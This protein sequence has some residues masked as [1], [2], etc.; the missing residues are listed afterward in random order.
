MKSFAAIF[1]FLFSAGLLFA[2]PEKNASVQLDFS[3]A[4]EPGKTYF[5]NV[6]NIRTQNC[7]LKY[8]G[9]RRIP[10]RRDSSET[11]LAGMLSYVSKSDDGH[12]IR[13]EFICRID[14]LS[15]AVNGRRLEFP[16]LTGCSLH[17]TAGPGARCSMK[18]T[19]DKAAEEEQAARELLEGG[20]SAGTP[21]LSP[22]AEM[23]LR[24]VFTSVPES[25][26]AYLGT[27]RTFERGEKYPVAM[28]MLV[29]ALRQRKIPA[30]A[31]KIDAFAEYAGT[32][33]FYGFPVCRVDLLA[34]GNGIPGYDFKLEVS[35]FMPAEADFPKCGPVRISRKAMEVVNSYLPEGGALIA[36]GKFEVVSNDMTDLVLIPADRLKSK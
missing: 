11:V 22:E 2:A 35:L 29:Q 36:G 31:A 6:R 17:V 25:V 26:S 24:P 23:L 14:S 20:S 4:P 27:Q 21:V 33:L 10:A 12:G 18:L 32:T 19:S 28:G 3:G 30:E 13:R 34:Q 8:L 15:G 9:V 5:F 1:Y 7:E 16:E